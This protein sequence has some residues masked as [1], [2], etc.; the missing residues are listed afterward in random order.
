MRRKLQF[1]A[2]FVVGLAHFLEEFGNI[3]NQSD[4]E[5]DELAT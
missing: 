4:E 2:M 1:E 3:D 5:Y